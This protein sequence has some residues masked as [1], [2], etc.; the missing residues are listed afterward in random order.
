MANPLL[1]QQCDF[2]QLKQAI[3]GLLLQH[4]NQKDFSDDTVTCI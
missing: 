4:A 1:P 3:F 2:R